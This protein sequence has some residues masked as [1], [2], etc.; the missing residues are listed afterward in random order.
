MFIKQQI[1]LEVCVYHGKQCRVFDSCACFTGQLSGSS[2]YFKT[3]LQSITVHAQILCHTYD[4]VCAVHRCGRMQNLTNWTKMSLCEKQRQEKCF[5]AFKKWE[6]FKYYVFNISVSIS[7]FAPSSFADWPKSFL[8]VIVS[9]GGLEVG[10]VEDTEQ[11]CVPKL[12]P[13]VADGGITS[14]GGLPVTFRELVFCLTRSLRFSASLVSDVILFWFVQIG[15]SSSSSLDMVSELLS[16][17]PLS[18]GLGPRSSSWMRL[19]LEDPWE[20]ESDQLNLRFWK[21]KM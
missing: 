9:T 7:F 21:K 17:E 15:L 5:N 13:S 16:H 18:L 3:L 6:T 1:L 2:M 8:L 14:G 19:L 12:L 10:V 4:Y 11:S 20:S